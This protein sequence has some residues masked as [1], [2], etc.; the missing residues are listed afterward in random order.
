MTAVSASVIGVARE[1]RTLL[2]DVSLEVP[3]GS[4][5]GIVG[6]NGAGKS[7]LLRVLAGDIHPDSGKALIGDVDVSAAG[8]RRLATLRAF[9]GPQLASDVAFRAGDVVAMGRH[10]VLDSQ[11]ETGDDVVAAAMADFDV[12]DLSH[13]VMRT[14]SSGE[15]QRVH[16][17]RAIVQQTPVV[18]LDEPTSALDV[19]H[20]EK[21][22]QVLRALADDGV[23]V[24]AVLHDLNLAAASADRLLLLNA[25]AAAAYG[26]PREVLTS[27]LLSAAYSYSMQVIDHPLRNCPLVLSSPYKRSAERS[28]GDEGPV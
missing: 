26:T 10:P 23:A 5:V 6:P 17:A 18:L 24:V 16:L 1:G 28:E 21:V 9:V 15:Q 20:Q 12:A 14:L 27:E 25:G 22:M 7:T 8:L 11:P 2:H 19:G 4:V 13:R 3:A